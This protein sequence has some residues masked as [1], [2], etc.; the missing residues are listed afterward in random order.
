MPKF[1]QGVQGVVQGVVQGKYIGARGLCRVCRDA[2]YVTRARGQKIITQVTVSKKFLLYTLHTLHTLHTPTYVCISLFFLLAQLHAHPAQTYI[3]PF[4]LKNK[5]I[6]REEMAV[7]KAGPENIKHM[8]ALL[9]DELPEFHALVK[10]LYQAKMITGLRGLTIETDPEHEQAAKAVPATQYTCS[11]CN[12]WHRDTVGFGA[13]IGRCD[14]NIDRIILPW[15][16][17]IA[18]RHIKP[19]EII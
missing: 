10:E 1:V 11:Q 2:L 12:H 17:Q 19:T 8:Q 6:E 14:L 5:E 4:F 16:D 7:F 9:R 13:G 3:Y 18:C 15:P